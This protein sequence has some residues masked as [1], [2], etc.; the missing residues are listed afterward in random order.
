MRNNNTQISMNELT[1]S[2]QRIKKLDIHQKKLFIELN[3]T[4]ISKILLAGLEPMTF[5]NEN[6]L[7]LCRCSTVVVKSTSRSYDQRVQIHRNLSTRTSKFV[8]VQQ[9]FRAKKNP[10]K[11]SAVLHPRQCNLQQWNNFSAVYKTSF[12]FTK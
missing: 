6:K 1:C 12:Y 10:C 11:K 7:H 4:K 2:E 8:P 9:T 5:S 3:S